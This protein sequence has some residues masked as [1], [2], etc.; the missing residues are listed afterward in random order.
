[1]A[2]RKS[3]RLNSSHSVLAVLPIWQGRS[4]LRPFAPLRAP[5]SMAPRIVGQAA[6]CIDLTHLSDGP[7]PNPLADRPQTVGG[8]ALNAHL[9]NDLAFF[10]RSRQTP[11]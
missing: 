10:G 4:V 2:D 5:V 6:P 1:M 8:V 9:G 11:R 3:T 7:V